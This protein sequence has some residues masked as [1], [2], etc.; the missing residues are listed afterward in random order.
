MSAIRVI[1][2]AK[3][4]WT[5]E[6]LRVR[7]DGYHEV[8]SVLQTIDLRD[9]ITLEDAA[10][11]SI[12]LRGGAG[13][14]ADEPPERNLAYRAAVAFRSRTGLRRGARITL[15]KAIPVAAGLG[16]G[17]SDGAAVL[18]GLNVLWD[19]QQ[20]ELNLVEVAGEIGSDPPFFIV[21]GTAEVSGRGERVAA[22]DD[23]IETA[24]LLATPPP[25]ERGEKTAAMFAALTPD[26]YSEGHA[27]NWLRETVDARRPI[28]DGA[29]MNVFERVIAREQPETA[30][31]M[32]AL[33][34]QGHV[35]HLCGAGPSFLLLA[36][37]E[38]EIG[39]ISDRIREL[40]FEPRLVRT[41]PRAAS[42]AIERL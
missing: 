20:P 13:P 36:P 41:L 1:A 12:E 4:N 28:V 33:S 8:R 14:L 23:A 40:G 37:A 22:L 26:H 25:A 39:G 42:L 9:V 31:A 2:P 21:G 34:A 10:D 16:G 27:T 3:I 6:A 18:R 15:E 19:A 11:I 17:S 38:Q 32:S 35:P 30:N 7:P 24:L 5:L 29:L